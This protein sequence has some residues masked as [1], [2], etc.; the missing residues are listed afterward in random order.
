MLLIDGAIG[1]GGGQILRTALALSLCLGRPFRIERIRAN[2]RRPGLQRQHLAAVH[3][4][5]VVGRAETEGALLDSQTLEFRPGTVVPGEYHFDIGSAGSTTLVLQTILPPLMLANAPSRLKLTGGTHNPL[6]PPFEFL[7]AAYLPLLSAM[8]PQVKLTL[9]R[10][11]FYPAGGGHL[12]AEI[13]P[14]EQLLPLWCEERGTEIGRR[15]VARLSQLSRHIAEREL[16]VI[17]RAFHID[18]R[19]LEILEEKPGTGPG[20]TVSLFLEA[21]RITE[22]FTGFGRKG[23]PAERVAQEVVDAAR[24]YLHAGVPVG[25][26]LADQL[27]LPL[28]LAGSGGFVTLPPSRHTTTNMAII[29]RFTGL[30]FDSNQLD[31]RRWHITLG[32]NRPGERHDAKLSPSFGRR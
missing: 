18:D 32:S 14:V 9:E 7:Q 19:H 27:L 30:R 23:V 2:R 1:E 31:A 16:T 4:A 20:N 22:V 28:A 13:H 10:A 12:T 8:G 24:E 21:E 26:H 29:E 3:A 25:K 5:T 15:A 11:G 6:A 17:A